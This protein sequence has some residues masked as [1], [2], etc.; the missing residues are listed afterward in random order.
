MLRPHILYGEE[1][2]IYI[3]INRQRTKRITQS[4]SLQRR[5]RQ[6]YQQGL[7]I[8][9]NDIFDIFSFLPGLI[10]KQDTKPAYLILEIIYIYGTKIS[11]IT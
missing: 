11:I 9:G 10:K 7:Q 4:Q 5:H 1:K 6:S 3:A 2:H 8:F